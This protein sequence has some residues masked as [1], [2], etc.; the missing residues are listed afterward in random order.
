MPGSRFIDRAIPLQSRWD[1]T[2]SWFCK[3]GSRLLFLW[4]C[5][6]VFFMLFY[7]WWKSECVSLQLLAHL[8]WAFTIMCCPSSSSVNTA[9]FVIARAID[10]KHD[11]P[12][13][14]SVRSDWFLAWP[15]GGQNLKHKKCYDSWT[16]Y[17]IILKF[18][19]GVY[20][21]RIH[22]IHRFLIWPTFEGQWSNFI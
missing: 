22:Y 17:W 9:R 7:A 13:Q 8:R 11:L 14:I 12:D 5:F 3:L 10:L 19:S 15:S 18:L 20:L 1:P 2:F 6:Y 21:V 16:N 4:G